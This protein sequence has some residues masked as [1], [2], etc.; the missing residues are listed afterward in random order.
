MDNNLYSSVELSKRDFELPNIKDAEVKRRERNI[1]LCRNIKE[2][3]R[4]SRYRFGCILRKETT[5][6]ETET[7]YE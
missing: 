1:S 3:V 6:P 4:P 5:K 2:R 7:G